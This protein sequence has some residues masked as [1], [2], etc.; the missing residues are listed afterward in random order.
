[1]HIQEFRPNI[2][3]PSS[4]AAP[5]RPAER[6]WRPFCPDM[7]DIAAPPKAPP[8]A[9]PATPAIADASLVV[10]IV[11]SKA[12]RAPPQMDG[13]EPASNPEGAVNVTPPVYRNRHTSW[14][15]NQVANLY[16]TYIDATITAAI[17]TYIR[18]G[19]SSARC[20]CLT[21]ETY[22]P[23]ACSAQLFPR[24]SQRLIPSFPQKP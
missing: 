1:V 16:A 24:T 8:A 12:G 3:Q 4:Q 19:P 15:I 20:A 13:T 7:A 14:C 21:T 11:V 5:L 17:S 10:N 6:T 9:P 22:D 23:R 2:C 18:H